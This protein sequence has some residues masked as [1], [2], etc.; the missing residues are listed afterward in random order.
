MPDTVERKTLTA[1]IVKDSLDTDSGSFEAILSHPDTDREGEQV[2][3]TE[4]QD[5]PSRIP[6]NYDHLMS[7]E[8]LVGSGEPVIKDG[9]LHIK[10]TFASTPKAQEIR[11]LVKEGH[12]TSMSVE[13]LRKTETDE[14]GLKTTTRELIGGAFTPYPAQ[15]KAAI[16]SAKAGARNSAADQQKVQTVHDHAVSLGASCDGSKALSDVETKDSTSEYVN[17]NIGGVEY[18]LTYHRYSGYERTGEIFPST[19]I[20]VENEGKTLDNAETK[21][22]E[23][24]TEEV[25]APAADADAESFLFNAKATRVRLALLVKDSE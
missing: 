7:A 2:K 15:P 16:L 4:W 10:G 21:S 19:L 18:L 20:P 22:A 1:A 11:T 17:V 6:L 5:L 14:K 3:T 25:A 24:A 13:F 8:G 23:A 9:A 12:L